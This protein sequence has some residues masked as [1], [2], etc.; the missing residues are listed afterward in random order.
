MIKGIF[1]SVTASFGFGGVY[2]LSTVLRPIEGS[3]LFGVRTLVT[4][5]FVLF[6]IVLLHKQQEFIDFLKR[7]KKQPHLLAVIILGGLNMGSQMWLFLYAPV[8]GK[9]IEVSI[10]YLLLPLIMVL[11]GR[12][13][14]KERL[15][16]IKAVAVL[17]ALIGVVSKII[18]T[19]A[20]SWETAFVCLGYPIYFALR[21]YFNMLHISAFAL[22]M[23]SMV[24]ASL[25]FASQIDFSFAE[26]QNPTIYW[27]LFLLGLVGGTAFI[28]YIM[29]SQLLPINL[30]GLLGY[31][32][33]FMMLIVSFI[34]GERL[35]ETSYILMICLFISISLLILDGVIKN[36]MKVL[37]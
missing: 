24:P 34:I 18:L 21:K 29:S 28:F 37:A 32:E 1:F 4:L 31:L 19:G 23:L 3:Q 30:L 6:A 12:L 13:F 33:P 22:E 17:F 20:F 15:T 26:I 27:G 16:T 5:P 7:I 35:D 10:G 11:F 8:S 36:K 25:Y 14:F 2:Y 9:A